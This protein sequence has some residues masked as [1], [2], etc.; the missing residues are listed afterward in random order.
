MP[1]QNERRSGRALAMVFP[2]SRVECYI[3]TV[4][5]SSIKILS[6]RDRDDNWFFAPLVCSQ[7]W[8]HP[9]SPPKGEWSWLSKRTYSNLCCYSGA[10]LWPLLPD[11]SPGAA[12]CG[13]GW[14]CTWAQNERY[15]RSLW[16]SIYLYC[17]RSIL[18]SLINWW[19]CM[20]MVTGAG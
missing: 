8:R 6:R 13:D 9:L 14:S 15:R 3:H 7:R 4:M 16:S 5:K 12:G 11:K 18:G 2:A 20:R 17:A 19:F 1:V 10:I